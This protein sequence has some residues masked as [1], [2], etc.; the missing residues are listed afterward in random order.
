MLLLM[1]K[2]MMLFLFAI[3]PLK[4]LEV[5]T[6]IRCS[7]VSHEFRILIHIWDVVVVLV[8][9]GGC[10]FSHRLTLEDKSVSAS[11]PPP[12]PQLS[13]DISH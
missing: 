2:M 7:S 4:D 11:L 9:V 13:I 6:D 10:S 3:A 12:P 1:K 8:V 5:V